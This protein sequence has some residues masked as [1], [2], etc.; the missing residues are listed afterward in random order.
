M[1]R[2][3]FQNRLFDIETIKHSIELSRCAFRT[4]ISF[5]R[6]NL[7]R[8][9]RVDSLLCK[10]LRIEVSYELCIVKHIM[11]ALPNKFQQNQDSSGSQKIHKIDE[12]ALEYHQVMH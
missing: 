1:I 3:M 8:N 10:C 4:F 11:F 9:V 6:L 2:C 5:D 12:Y 7:L